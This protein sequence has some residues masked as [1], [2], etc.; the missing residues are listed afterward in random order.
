MDNLLSISAKLD[1]LTSN[2]D[3]YRWQMERDLKQVFAD[4]DNGDPTHQKMLFDLALERFRIMQGEIST[5]R[6]RKRKLAA[7]RGES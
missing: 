1:K 7:F 3:G 6:E 2:I 5:L 4:D